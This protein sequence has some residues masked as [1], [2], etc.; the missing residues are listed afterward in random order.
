MPLHDDAATRREAPRGSAGLSRDEAIRRLALV[1][2]NALPKAAPIRL[3]WRF[4]AQF[5]SALLYLLLFALVFGLAAWLYEGAH[6]WP[7]EMIAIAAVLL[8]NAGLGAFQEHR[9]EQA[10][11]QLEALAAPLAWV[12]RDGRFSRVPSRELVPGDVLRVEAGERLPADGEF[13][14]AHGVLVDEAVL[15]GESIPI[16]KAAGDESFSGTLIV[17]GQGLLSVVRTGPASAMGQLATLLGGIR[18]EPTPLERRLDALGHQIA[19]LV[20][21]LAILLTGVLVAIEGVGHLQQAIL[22]AAALA[23][24]AVPEGLPAVVTLT[25]S[26]GVQ[27]M[28]RRKAV[29][30]RLSAVEALGSVTV[31][32]TDKT[33]T[34]TE[35]RMAVQALDS[36]A[37]EIALRAMTLANDADDD[38]AAGD[39]LDHGLLDYARAQG[40]EIRELRAG[41]PRRSLRPFDSEWK[42]MRV[43]VEE[44]GALR[45]Y[46]KGA[47]E[48]LLERCTLAGDVRE[49]WLARAEAGAED[50]YRVL[51]LATGAG[52]AE[53]DLQFL[54]L[55]LLWDPPRREVPAAIRSATAAG[56]RVL[57]VTGDHPGTARAVAREVGLDAERVLVGG[58]IEALSDAQLRD[59][60]RDVQVLA[61]VDPQHKLRII[62]VLQRDGEIV[63]MTGDGVN[64]ALALKRADVGVAMGQRGSDV[65]REVA[66]LVL[67]DDD[68]ASIVG[69]IEEGRSIYESIQNFIRFLFSTNVALVTLVVVGALGSF[70]TGM[71]DVAGGLLLPLTAIQLLWINFL[72]DGPAALALALDRHP[73]V[74]KRAPKPPGEPLLD[75]AARRFVLSTGL[76][77]AGVGAAF[78]IVLPVWGYTVVVARTAVFLLE[79]VA[80][81]LTAY[82][83]RRIGAQAA[84]NRT[85]HAVILGSVVLQVLTV[86][87]PALRQA[88]GLVA[89]DG[90]VL[91]MSAVAVLITWILSEAI[92][93]ALPGRPRVRE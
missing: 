3:W 39:P 50:G 74:M 42:F 25:L 69:A 90:P 32:A 35:N 5:H 85:L 56:V 84:S 9:S 73:D 44:D 13:L 20:G 36:P 37:P 18:A 54:G 6:G 41:H 21:G 16:D 89:L 81:L 30:R 14:E 64:D 47:P 88:L 79:S 38:S 52:E 86:T 40:V 61:R 26:L 12:L 45:S 27:R 2:P 7:A 31:I 93:R 51:A 63:A 71:R 67:L 11:A 60:L 34:L 22:F 48:V 91:A 33:G 75:R 78:L 65:A 19:L 15:T 58:E 4:L 24:A 66:D 28:A 46:F 76:L 43:G 8:L 92:G 17:R 70:A 53:R 55:V 1:G 23:V 72:G 59:A 29:V 62:E 83:A 87:V 68:F 82:P 80:Q 57:L 49:N 77:K 10:L